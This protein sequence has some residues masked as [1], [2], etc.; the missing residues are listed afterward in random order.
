MIIIHDKVEQWDKQMFVQDPNIALRDE[1]A[2]CWSCRKMC[3][4]VET[5]TSQPIC[6]YSCQQILYMEMI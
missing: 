2:P 4:T 6:C 5:T 3:C 1:Y